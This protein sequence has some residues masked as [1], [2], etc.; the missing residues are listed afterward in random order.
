MPI[1]GL[2]T[3]WGI[4]KKNGETSTAIHDF[5]GKQNSITSWNAKWKEQ[6]WSSI[7]CDCDIQYDAAQSWL[8]IT[9]GNLTLE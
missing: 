1:N 2:N 9:N 7:C 8:L 6:D 4:I 3:I 5:K